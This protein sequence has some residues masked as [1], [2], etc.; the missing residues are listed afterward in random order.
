MLPLAKIPGLLCQAPE[1]CIGRLS[2]HRSG[3][4]EQTELHMLP[5]HTDWHG[6]LH[7]ACLDKS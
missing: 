3:R 2:H 1:L 6:S 4:D 5:L 7:E